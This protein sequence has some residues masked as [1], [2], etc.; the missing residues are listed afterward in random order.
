MSAPLRPEPGHVG[1]FREVGYKFGRRIDV[2]Y[3]QKQLR[4]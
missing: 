1:T 2:G 4:P 3:W